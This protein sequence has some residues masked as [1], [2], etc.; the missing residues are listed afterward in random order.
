MSKKIFIT[1]G[2]RSGKSSF[3]EAL[4]TELPGKRAY[5]ATAQAL[6]PEMAARIERHRR[7]RD[8]VWETFEEPLAVADLLRRLQGSHDVVLIDCLTLWLNNV[9]LG[10]VEADDAILSMSEELVSAFSAFSGTC[11]VVSNEVGLGIVPDNPLARRFRDLAGIV[12]Q[13]AAAAADE[14]YFV[15][16]G[17]PVRMK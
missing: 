3:A 12:N 14:A 17:I 1:G 16:S 10:R 9:I 2:A 4:A 8:A 15:A 5:I 13:R 6:D 7:E 11:I